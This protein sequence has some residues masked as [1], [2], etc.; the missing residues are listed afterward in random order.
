MASRT[1]L[2][3]RSWCAEPSDPLASAIGKQ[4]QSQGS[5]VILPVYLF[6]SADSEAFDFGGAVAFPA[7]GSS[8]VAV[9]FTVPDGYNGII[10][11]LGNQF[12][13][14]GFNEG[15]GGLYW[16]LLANNAPIPNYEDI[17]IT[18]GATS[19]PRKVNS[20][21]VKMSQLIQ[22]V[23]FNVSIVQSG[24]IAAGTLGGWFYPVNEEP[25]DSQ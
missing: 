12:F 13:G 2:T 21:R 14:G 6:P 3:S 1:N 8:A 20:V 19:N 24:Q 11:G 5:P 17:L 25:V 9:Q 15:Q 22:L 7:I 4:V 18:L 10:D 23:I 16:Q